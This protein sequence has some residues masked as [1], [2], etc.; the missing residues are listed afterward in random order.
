MPDAQAREVLS[1]EE[2]NT[3][4]GA[5]AKGNWIHRFEVDG[6]REI[7]TPES[8][9][10]RR[11]IFDGVFASLLVDRSVLVLEEGSGIYPALIHAAG[12]ERVTASSTKEATRELI[13]DVWAFFDV[14]AR[15]IDSRLVGFYDS[16]P[17]VDAT[18]EAGHDF[19]VVLNQI[20]PMFGSSGQSFDA[21]AEACAFLVT[22]GL[23][24]DWTDAE[25]ATP[26]PPP[27]YN[28]A[29]FCAALRKK[30]E[31]VTCYSDWLVVATGKLP[32]GVQGAD[33]QDR[34]G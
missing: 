16:E 2:L 8:S 30:F 13:R 31:Y 11:R 3:R 1:P 17:Y 33:G 34:P 10:Y 12:A 19:L 28:R 14:P 7:S 15:V 4:I 25:W 21:I 27:E 32:S 23:V 24:F 29:A 20:W 9:A 22:D 5:V 26:P 18:H 6:A